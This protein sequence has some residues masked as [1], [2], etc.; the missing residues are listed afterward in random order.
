MR[1]SRWSTRSPPMTRKLANPVGDIT[2]GLGP[3]W[4]IPSDEDDPARKVKVMGPDGHVMA[5]PDRRTPLYT[6]YGIDLLRWSTLAG[7]EIQIVVVS[8]HDSVVRAL[9]NIQLDA[10]SRAIAISVE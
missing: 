9:S 4:A 5:V 2:L 7:S 10:A 6:R 3:E 1:R 8:A